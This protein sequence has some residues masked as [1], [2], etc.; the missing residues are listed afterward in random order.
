MNDVI[1]VLP[2]SP[3]K[4]KVFYEIIENMMYVLSKNDIDYVIHF[5]NPDI[6]NE[7]STEKLHIMYCAEVFKNHPKKFIAMQFEQLYAR[8]YHFP[9]SPYSEDYENYVLSIFKKAQYVFDYSYKNTEFLKE[10]NLKNVITVPY[11]F[12]PTLSIFKKP[13]NF[14][15]KNIDILWY[16]NYCER[17]KNILDKFTGLENIK[18]KFE[19]E[20][21]WDNKI[22]ELG[23]I[24]HDKTDIVKKSKIVLNIKYDDPSYS[25]LETPRII[26]AISN[27]CL[28]IS[29]YSSD[30]ELNKELKENII[31]C[32][33]SQMVNIC[34]FYLRN[35][36]LL[37]KKIY[38]SYNWLINNYKYYDKVPI[39]LIN[40]LI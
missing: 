4:I 35:S 2:Y 11:A 16:G 38:E 10:K 19:I 27:G 5:L 32:H 37:N 28:V 23:E 17:R 39:D 1:I 40:N 8:L 18:C 34:L 20:N 13:L 22:K 12:T 24:S 9:N 7:F 26:H 31:L 21:L 36:I 25:I 30:T 15:E 6:V 14:I 33:H 3:I 29:E